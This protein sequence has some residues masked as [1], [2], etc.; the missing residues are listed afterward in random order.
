M[1]E[2]M[3]QYGLVLLDMLAVLMI[4]TIIFSFMRSGGVLSDIVVKYM[5]SISG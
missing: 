3:E 5:Y 1:R 2:I 4:F